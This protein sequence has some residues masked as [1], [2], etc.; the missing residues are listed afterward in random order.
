M[1]A[2]L[3]S[4][5]VLGVDVRVCDAGLTANG[6]EESRH[7]GRACARIAGQKKLEVQ[8]AFHPSASGEVS[9]VARCPAGPRWLA[10]SRA[11]PARA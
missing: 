6:I 4:R 3:W 9:P 5:H 1:Q 8:L 7:T 2:Q 10:F 11:Q